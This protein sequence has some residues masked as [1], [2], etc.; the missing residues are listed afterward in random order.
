[1]TLENF[2]RSYYWRSGYMEN[3]E[4]V[5][6]YRAI[7]RGRGWWLI[8]GFSLELTLFVQLVGTLGCWP[9]ADKFEPIAYRWV[10]RQIDTLT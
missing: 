9:F 6:L 8:T 3:G 10:I 1:M 4:K 5:R 2:H 7:A